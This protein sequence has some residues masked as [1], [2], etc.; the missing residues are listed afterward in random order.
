MKSF[1]ADLHLHGP[2]S[3]GVSKNMQIP[4]I[5]EQARLKGLGLL[6]TA[7]ILHQG[8]FEHAR[9]NLIEESNGVFAEKKT[10]V[11]FVLGTE[12]ECNK[13][14]HHLIYLPDF[15]AA[16]SLK[17][18]MKG[19]TIFDSWG[20]GRPRVYFEPEEIAEK[21]E[22]AGG[23][24]GPAHAFTPYFSIYAHCDSLLDCY[25]G[26]AEKV[27]F[28]E[29]GLSADTDLADTISGNHRVQFCTFSDAHSPWPHRIGRE[30]TRMRMKQGSFNELEK[31]L[32]SKEKVIELNAGLNPREGK[33]HMSACNS[34]YARFRFEDAVRFGWKCKC[35]GQIKKGVGDRIRELADLEQGRH[36]EFRP[37]YMHSLPLAE[38]IQIAKGIKGIQTSKV[39]TL[40]R[41]F[42]DRFGSEI[43]VLVDVSVGDL[44]EVD[45]EV[46]SRIDAFRKGWVVYVPGGG[47][48]YGT[49][50]ICSSK[51]EYLEKKEAVE[52][53]NKFENSLAGQHT[54]R[55]F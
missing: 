7:D 42:V 25:G 2:Y 1:D 20:C 15:S 37:P 36:P 13:R 4:T 53:G 39:Q 44:G 23:I 45:A 52:K 12:V 29:L 27:G 43:G 51:E 30:F 24:I 41:D 32:S 54:L 9:G 50:V 26:M 55:E 11:K 5:A 38:V 10:G 40:W 47:G 6:C 17:E 18:S 14:I 22:K 33:Y 48:E 28:M 21:V 16:E 46:A 31:V 34:C 49:P 35:G 8:W 19:R 3:G